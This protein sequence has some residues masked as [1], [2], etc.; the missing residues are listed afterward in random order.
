MGGGKKRGRREGKQETGDKARK[1]DEESGEVPNDQWQNGRGIIQKR[2]IFTFRSPRKV[3]I[4][5][6]LAVHGSAR[7]HAAN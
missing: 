1:I 7:S 3:K 6:E 2:T 4:H 5:P